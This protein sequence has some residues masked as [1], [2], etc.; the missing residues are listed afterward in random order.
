M[1]LQH[2]AGGCVARRLSFCEHMHVG[3]CDCAGVRTDTALPGRPH[4]CM[5]YKGFVRF[6]WLLLCTAAR[7]V[8]AR[9]GIVAG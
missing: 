7:A 1:V 9:Y 4:A 3:D 8:T 6:T 5:A 2:L